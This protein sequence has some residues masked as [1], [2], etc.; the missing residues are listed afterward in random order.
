MARTSYAFD[1]LHRPRMPD[2]QNANSF[3]AENGTDLQSRG[4]PSLRRDS[5]LVIEQFDQFDEEFFFPD[6]SDAIAEDNQINSF[7]IECSDIDDLVDAM[8][9]NQDERLIDT[10]A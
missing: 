7:E 9:L 4:E 8:D 1:Q 3:N 2:A 5:D 6:V 10:N